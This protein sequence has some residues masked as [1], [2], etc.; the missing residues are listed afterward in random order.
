MQLPQSS[1]TDWLHPPEEQEGLQRYVETIRERI[2]L[3][4]MTVV[5]T[6]GI[7]VIYVATAT[8]KYDAEADI[9]V[10]PV[11]GDNPL[12]TSL[13]LLHESADPTRDV[14][15]ASRLVRNID[16]A[17]R[18]KRAI[19]SDASAQSLL[20]N[21][22]A[23]PVA[24]SN[25]V[26][27]TA[28][29]TS[30]RVAQQLANAFAEEAVAD[31]T[32]QMHQQIDQ[33]LAQLEAQLEQGD[34]PVA[35][36]VPLADQIAQ[37][38]TLRSSSDPTMRV[39]TKAP[40]PTTQASPQSTLSIAGGIVAGLVLGIAAAFA[41]QVLDPRLR[42]EAQLRRNYRLPILGRIPKDP[43]A[44]E[45]PL[46]P[47]QASSATGE[48]YRALRAT[49][50]GGR[51][52]RSGEGKVILVTGSSPSEGKT[53]TA[54]NLA[55]SLALAGNRVILI[56]SDL[57]RPVLAKVVDA[58]PEHGGVVSVLIENTTLAE[59][60]IPSPT[61]GPNL[62]LLLSDYE[63]GWIAELF[64]I[65]TAERMIQDAR[66]MADIVIIDSAPLNEVVDALPLALQADEVLMVVRLGVTRLDK[67]SQLAE[68][69]GENG[70][71]PV[72]FAVVGTPRPKRSEYHYYAEPDSGS[73][74]GQRQLLS[75][76][77]R[78]FR[79]TRGQEPTRP[80]D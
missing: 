74:D 29:E 47:R 69:L 13:G 4:L 14:E 61:Y 30:P 43:G 73:Q 79:S 33:Q 10:T 8:K 37:L 6:T 60:L 42:R 45:S 11:S 59:S 20:A 17:T 49:L 46:A 63:G 68:L 71:R 2:L 54:V 12:L 76:A 31:R 70:V 18:V 55:T 72:G 80:R 23:E 53:T 67:L 77:R 56:E 62:R 52:E 41:S 3:I 36:E 25:I 35:G 9:L 1:S 65:P 58:R 26:A 32:E 66:R 27:V 48:A 5:I 40:L 57:R 44:K 50:A 22:S 7:A 39:E 34:V 38:Q 19:D 78:A 15:T 21:V 51:R 24:Q 16:V 75:E 64:S 28:R